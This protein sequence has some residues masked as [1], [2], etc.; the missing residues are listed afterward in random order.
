MQRKIIWGITMREVIGILSFYFFFSLLYHVVLW[1]ISY[2]YEENGIWS[3][4][5]LSDYWFSSGMQY[6]FFF[7]ASFIIWFLGIYLLKKKSNTYQIA[8]VVMLIPIV[9]YIVR[10]IRYSIIDALGLGRLREAGTIW[11]LYIPLLFFLIQFGCFFAYRYFIE[12]QRK[13]IVEGELRQAALKSELTAI[14]AQLNPHFLYNVFNTINASVPPKQE[15]TRQLIATLADLFRYQL[16]ASKKEL[17]P[18]SEEIEFVNKYLELEKARFEERLE[19]EMDVPIELHSE[20]V[21]PM[22]LQPLVENSVKH[23]ISNSLKGGKISITIFKD[24]DKL[25]FEI[26]DTG[27]GVEDKKSLFGKGVG[28]SNTQ[29]RLQ[30]MYQS[31]LEFL[32]NEPQGLKIRFSL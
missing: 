32:D 14:K 18:L 16:R 21:P 10:Q 19:I 8:M 27:T 24:E 3:W 12:N 30:K 9:V 17:V 26:A 31:Q 22:L 15:K 20:M 5:N 25:K 29:L 11:D 23:G 13:L 6:V 1:Y 28:L 4:I 7:I 2:Y